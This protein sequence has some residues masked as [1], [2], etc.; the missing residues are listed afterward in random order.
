MDVTPLAGVGE[1]LDHRA[2]LGQGGEELGGPGHVERLGGLDV[3]GSPT[4]GEEIRL[5]RRVIIRGQL[6]D[7]DGPGRIE[8]DGEGVG[9]LT[10]GD[11]GNQLLVEGKGLGRRHGRRA[12]RHIAV[13]TAQHLAGRA[14]RLPPHALFRVG[15]DRRA[16]VLQLA[17]VEAVQARA[18]Q[19][20]PEVLQ[21]GA[22]RPRSPRRLDRQHAQG[23]RPLLDGR[24][25]IEKGR[26]TRGNLGA[27]PAPEGPR[28]D[29]LDHLTPLL[30]DR[31]R[32]APRR[33]EPCDRHFGPGQ[34]G[35]GHHDGPLA[36][37]GLDPHVARRR[38]R[39]RAAAAEL[40]LDDIGNHHRIR[41]ADHDDRHIARHVPA[42]VVVAEIVG[43]HRLDRLLD[44][45][46]QAAAESRFGS[47]LLEDLVLHALL[48]AR[49][50]ALLLEDDLALAVD[51]GGQQAHAQADVR[52]VEH[53]LLDALAA[54]A[55][56]GQ[57]IG[58][59]V[60]AREGVLV[61]TEGQPE[62]LEEGNDGARREVGRPVERHVLEVVREAPR[63]FGLVEGARRDVEPDAHAALGVLVRA[64]DVTEPVGQR[65][66]HQRGVGRELGVLGGGCGRARRPA[67]EPAISG[68]ARQSSTGPGT[69]ACHSLQGREWIR[70]WVLLNGDSRLLH[71][72][73]GSP[74][75]PR[76]V[77]GGSPPPR[78]GPP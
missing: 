18:L 25:G 45:D 11:A 72:I 17:L 66:H 7:E 30:T 75:A 63:R 59:L 55:G 60:K 27:H 49:A 40:L 6:G 51:L 22:P 31:Q 8:I 38:L 70:G 50:R 10:R 41:V 23:S 24:V 16:R 47:E 74:K 52:H 21:H 54:A 36:Y 35:I 43:A 5:A 2:A 20:G 26:A 29:A 33:L 58:G 68:A 64:D 32:R 77:G 46:G 3:H 57:L 73:A 48:G 14:R 53:A 78:R 62:R 28:A 19:L 65:A 69:L 39:F 9:H 15:D 76:P 67:P 56:Q 42:G 13:E 37:G 12:A 61:A 4:E 1:R 44:A 34:L 71:S